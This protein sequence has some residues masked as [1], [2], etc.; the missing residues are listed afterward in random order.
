MI[1]PKPKGKK[2]GSFL[3]I[4]TIHGPDGEVFIAFKVGKFSRSLHNPGETCAPLIRFQRE[5]AVMALSHAPVTI[6]SRKM[7][8]NVR[9]MNVFIE[10]S[11]RCSRT[12]RNAALQISV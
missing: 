7:R 10:R 12:C 3:D 1:K 8:T 5:R 2:L 11:W 4:S 9:S 6:P